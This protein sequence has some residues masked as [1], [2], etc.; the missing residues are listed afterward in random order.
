MTYIQHILPATCPVFTAIIIHSDNN[1][2][3]NRKQ[4]PDHDVALYFGL[5]EAFDTEK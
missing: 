2:F 4:S 5:I 1:T 3:M